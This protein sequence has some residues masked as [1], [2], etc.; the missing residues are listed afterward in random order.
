MGKTK[1]CIC[2][3]KVES[4]YWSIKHHKDF[5]SRVY[6]GHKGCLSLLDGKLEQGI[7]LE[8]TEYERPISISKLF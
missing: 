4:P 5:K 8:Y 6:E 2:D 3:E 1:C 7:E